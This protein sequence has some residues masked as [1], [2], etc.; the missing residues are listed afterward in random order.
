MTKKPAAVP[1]ETPAEAPVPPKQR[2]R[3]LTKA[4][5]TGGVFTEDGDRL[6]EAP[7]PEP[8]DHRMQKPER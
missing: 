1:D 8:D 6:V 2:E 5:T 4:P 7:K 3:E